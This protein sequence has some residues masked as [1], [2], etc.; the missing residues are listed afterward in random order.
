MG[1]LY[2][3][4]TLRTVKKIVIFFGGPF[5]LILFSRL[6]FEN[7]KLD[8]FIILTSSM[9]LENN[10]ATQRI[11]ASPPANFSQEYSMNTPLPKVMRSVTL[12]FAATSMLVK[13]C[14]TQQDPQ[15]HQPEEGFSN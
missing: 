11:N 10:Q 3:S 7:L 4:S 6:N 9:M 15:P 13:I 8:R 2:W 14:P 5:P 12:N 1:H